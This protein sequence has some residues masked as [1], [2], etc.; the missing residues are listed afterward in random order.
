[1]DNFEV[2]L[3]SF[4]HESNS[5]TQQLSNSATQQLSNCKLLL[6]F[7]IFF[8]FSGF[9]PN[10]IFSQSCSS[11][12]SWEPNTTYI[13]YV[14]FEKDPIDT[15]NL[16]IHVI[17]NDDGN[18]QPDFSSNLDFTNDPYCAQWLQ[19]RVDKINFHMGN[20]KPSTTPNTPGAF[21]PDYRVRIKLTSIEGHVHS[22]WYNQP[23]VSPSTKFTSLVASNPNYS[24]SFKDNNLHLFLST[25]TLGGRASG[26]VM[27]LGGWR[28]QWLDYQNNWLNNGF[29]W[30]NQQHTELEMN[31][32]H[33]FGHCMGLL[34]NFSNKFWNCS[35]N[36]QPC[37]SC[38]NNKCTSGN[39]ACNEQFNGFT[40]DHDIIQPNNYQSYPDDGTKLESITE[41][42]FKK[43]HWYLSEYSNS[44][45][46]K[47]VKAKCFKDVEP[48]PV[49]SWYVSPDIV[50][51]GTP[52]YNL[53]N[54][55]KKIYGDL[56][57]KPHTTVEL[58]CTLQMAPESRIIIEPA[59]RLIVNGGVI[60]KLDL[61]C[62]KKWYGIEVHGLAGHNPSAPGHGKLILT[63]GATIEHAYHA[64]H[65]GNYNVTID[66]GG[67]IIEATDANF[68]NNERT[69][70]SD[71][72]FYK[73]HVRGRLENSRSFFRN[74]EFELNSNYL[75][76]HSPPY[77]L[78]YLKNIGSV[79]FSNCKFTNSIPTGF[80]PNYTTNMDRCAA[81]KAN[82]GG[83]RVNLCEFNGLS[84]GVKFEGIDKYP[85]C[86]ITNSDFTNCTR[87]IELRAADY[88]EI[89]RNNFEECEIGTFISESKGFGIS[90]NTYKYSTT[91]KG[92]YL[93]DL[94]ARKNEVY[95]NS[96]DAVN[97]GIFTSATVPS[98]N[99]GLTFKCNYF[100]PGNI[101]SSDIHVNSAS[102]SRDQGTCLPGGIRASNYPAGNS[103][104]NGTPCPNFEYDFYT[105]PTYLGQIKYSHHHA[106]SGPLV[107]ECKGLAVQN[108]KCLSQYGSNSCPSAIFDGYSSPIDQSS[109]FELAKYNY[110]ASR[111]DHGG[112]WASYLQLV[113]GGNQVD[114]LSKIVNP[115]N[116]GTS[117]Y[118][119]LIN[120]VPYLSDTVL[121]SA[122]QRTPTLSQSE[123]FEVLDSCKPFNQIVYD[124]ILLSN[125]LTHQDKEYFLGF[126][127][128]YSP[129]MELDA[130]LEGV[131]QQVEARLDEIIRRTLLDT[132]NGF[133]YDTILFY[134]EQHESPER[135]SELLK[136]YWQVEDF[137][138][139][140]SILSKIGLE[141]EFG[142]H[143]FVLDK[144]Q[145]IIMN[146][147]P[148]SDL[149]N[150]S[151]SL[152]SI[153]NDT[154]NLGYGL[155]RN[156][157]HHLSVASWTM[158]EEPT[159]LASNSNQG[160]APHPPTNATSIISEQKSDRQEFT[161]YPNPNNGKFE[162][163][164]K[165]SV[166]QGEYRLIIHDLKGNKLLEK[167]TL[168]SD[169]K[170]EIHL[171]S[172][173][174]SVILSVWYKEHIIH[175]IPV[176]LT[177]E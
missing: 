164:W 123:L 83:L 40:F 76:I 122:I 45:I 95:R 154:T 30:G 147:F 132:S 174:S 167:N 70:S 159:T 151:L 96:F 168:I 11:T 80:F 150:D 136:F 162:L 34:H 104:S 113:D 107:P 26:Q 170:T 9:T 62:A 173:S 25:G 66:A 120:K 152:D 71:K 119:E 134:L 94:S 2:N 4:S 141:A 38:V 85:A 56:I 100:E 131:M 74:C 29:Q 106:T 93:K 125:V 153:A 105:Q 112:L 44:D 172:V 135:W 52:A 19:D 67:G 23:A 58:T 140:N 128:E 59:G 63:N 99:S 14:D 138:K 156:I 155:A 20:L 81:I 139:A 16:V 144:L 171:E 35:G 121:L 64:V 108:S 55:P 165:P 145:N 177:H 157:L 54:Y 78:A 158:E 175:R 129:R 79:E 53:I 126:Q 32:I 41:L 65:L 109:Q 143:F 117:I 86:Y 127:G 101:W 92:I 69:I 50:F 103:F 97:Q 3:K 51:N 1:M 8:G 39:N 89:N 87:G 110:F 146:D 7:T 111:S 124:Q 176:I 161:I 13:P 75:D 77:E 88:S 57:I 5:A 49:P 163:G 133:P 137:E 28:S 142:N 24:Q 12:V 21:I 160:S 31:F 27:T 91:G 114:L 115:N 72:Y 10:K 42:Q 102:V 61:P 68:I 90:D 46:S 166:L 6:A 48:F 98:G 149:L 82:N 43:I 60:T 47:C 84:V 33:E 36:T 148:Y 130:Q 37:S 17:Y 116:T 73:Y 15:V 18:G 22:S 169:E 118:D